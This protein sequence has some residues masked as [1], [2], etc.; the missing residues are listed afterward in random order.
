MTSRAFKRNSKRLREA[1]V[2]ERE[3]WSHCLPAGE[4]RGQKQC[5]LSLPY[6]HSAIEAN[7]QV[8]RLEGGLVVVLSQTSSSYQDGELL[9]L[10][11]FSMTA[12]T[13]AR[14]DARRTATEDFLSRKIQEY[15]QGG[16]EKLPEP[17]L[18][19]IIISI[20]NNRNIGN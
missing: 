19:A 7:H 3:P 4:K 1:E 17:V 13:P 18:R 20:I 12:M 6:F 10:H 16:R 9:G 2:A 11:N 14:S 8:T 15:C 5:K